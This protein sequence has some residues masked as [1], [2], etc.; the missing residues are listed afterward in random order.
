M[1]SFAVGEYDWLQDISML[2][3]VLS[4]LYHCHFPRDCHFCACCKISF[5][6]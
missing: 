1:A 6:V 2:D 3:L 4:W 5:D